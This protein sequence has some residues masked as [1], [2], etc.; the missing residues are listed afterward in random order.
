MV[1]VPVVAIRRPRPVVVR[2]AVALL[3][4]VSVMVPVSMMVVLAAPLG[5]RALE[6]RLHTRQRLNT[7]RCRER[8]GHSVTALYRTVYVQPLMTPNYQQHYTTAITK[9]GLL[10]L[11]VI[12]GPRSLPP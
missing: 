4:L 12:A 3:P 7:L 8:E 6:L 5:R 10:K 2:L 9:I 1:V 11:Q